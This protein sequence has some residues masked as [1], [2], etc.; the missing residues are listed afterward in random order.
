MH[1]TKGMST[2]LKAIHASGFAKYYIRTKSM[3]AR[4]VTYSMA[5]GIVVWSVNPIQCQ[6]FHSPA[7]SIIQI[8]MAAIV[9]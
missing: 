5:H 9:S 3:I 8:L 7:Y 1:S 2:F 4:I 6:T